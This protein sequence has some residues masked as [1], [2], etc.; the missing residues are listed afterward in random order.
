MKICD[1]SKLENILV[2]PILGN[3]NLTKPK[4]LLRFGFQFILYTILYC[5][6]TK[7]ILLT[8]IGSA[9]A[10][11][12]PTITDD[13]ITSLPLIS[14]SS[15]DD[16]IDE[17]NVAKFRVTA[18]EAVKSDIIIN[19][20]ADFENVTLWRQP[21]Q[22]V[23]KNGTRTTRL[24]L[25][26]SNVNGDEGLITLEIKNGSGYQPNNPTVATVKVIGQ[27]EE[28]NSQSRESIA[29]AVIEAILAFHE[30]S[31]YSS[32]NESASTIIV[33]KISVVA[34]ATRVDEGTPIHFK[35]SS[36]KNLRDDVVIDYTLTPEGEFFN[37]LGN[38]VQR[39]KLSAGQQ[40]ALVE[41]PTIDDKIIEQ[42]GALTLE[43]LDGRTYNLSNQS[44]ARVI[45]SDFAN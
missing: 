28:P 42:D 34:V 20:N 25:P 40:T 30:S 22:V 4:S 11:S 26:T 17:G 9:S 38:E 31:G 27:G 29:P 14:I 44:N 35:I 32:S 13:S 37:G 12:T 3:S 41:I 15:V 2:F 23:I 16:T 7:A 1:A 10:Q 5:V 8:S 21:K 39:I 18:N 6:A 43:L 19:V 24:S 33:P 45:V 36:N